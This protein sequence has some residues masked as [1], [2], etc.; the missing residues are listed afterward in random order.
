MK[1]SFFCLWKIL[2]FPAG[3]LLY[4]LFSFSSCVMPY[5]K[6]L[7]FIYLLE[8]SRRTDPSKRGILM[9]AS[10]IQAFWNHPAGPKTS[11]YHFLSNVIYLHLEWNQCPQNHLLLLS[12]HIAQQ[13]D[14]SYLWHMT[15][16]SGVLQLLTTYCIII[17]TWDA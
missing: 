5:F 11:L 15:L 16:R 12:Y 8:D 2:I 17:F 1:L 3:S 9:A 14:T 7:L 4:F 6:S 10:K 13:R